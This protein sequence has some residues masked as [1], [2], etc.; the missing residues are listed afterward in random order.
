MHWIRFERGGQTG[1]GTL[2]DGVI[3]VHEGDMFA[4]ARA[5]NAT[6]PLAE[7]T[8]LTPC[9]PTKMIALW[10]NFHALAAK[11]NL[12][13]P[14]EPLYLLK[15]PN[16]FLAGGQ[17]IR[18]PA[19]YTGKVVYEGELGVV[20]G[21]RASNVSE[22]DAAKYIFG[23]TCSNDVTA[24]EILQKDP[25]FA[26]W[27]RAKGFDTFGVFGPVIATG[28]DPLTLSVKTLL[29]GKERQNYPVSDMIFKPAQIVSLI[30]RDMT[31]Y[32]GDVISCG[33]S[34]GVGSMKPG[35]KIEVVIDGI[36]TL[37]NEY[38]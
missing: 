33:T 25:T 35:S 34:V 19:S 8:L 5:T 21:Q 13:A 29:D 28:L 18:V 17:T 14:P 6:V 38:K 24:A 4:G 37:S 11:L 26:Q 7:V 31:L 20:I 36:G 30:S 12:T 3:Q 9:V 10:N 27:T 32:P 2:R 15:A 22:A 16:S 1:F 23:Y